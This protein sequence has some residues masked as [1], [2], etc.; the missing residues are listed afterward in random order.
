MWNNL[1]L[2]IKRR[3]RQRTGAGLASSLTSERGFDV[4]GIRDFQMGD[5]LRAVDRTHFVRFG[6]AVVL[7]RSPDRN[8]VILFLVDVSASEHLGCAKTKKERMFEVLRGIAQAC[9]AKGHR[10]MFCA[11]TTRVE[12]ESNLIAGAHTLEGALTDLAN[13]AFREKKTNPKKALDRAWELATRSSC[14]VDLVCIASD[15]LFPKPYVRELEELSDATDVIALTMRDP[16]ETDMPPIAGGY[17]V[18]DAETGETYYASSASGVEPTSHLESLGIDVCIL[19]TQGSEDD[20]FQAIS[21]FFT[22][23]SEKGG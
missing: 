19:D 14:P 18:Q 5:S 1:P 13:R 23:R 3:V 4:K 17:M 10:I 8:A 20:D 9:F 15:F 2:F 12:Y 16:I 7:E 21:D 6:K 22:L 11:F